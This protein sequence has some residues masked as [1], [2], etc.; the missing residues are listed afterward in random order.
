MGDL[1]KFNLTD[2]IIKYRTYTYFE[3]GT[4]I[5]DTLVQAT[6]YPFDK[7][8]TVDIDDEILGRAKSRIGN[9]DKIVYINAKSTDALEK[10][11]PLIPKDEAV[12]WFLD[13]HF[14]G[15][16]YGKIS[17]QDSLRQYMWDAFPLE[18][19][20]NI[21]K[22]LRDTSKDVF[23]IDDFVL[24]EEGDYDTIKEGVIWKFGYLQDELGLKTNSD[25]LYSAFNDTHNF[26]KS[27]GQ[28]GHLTI[29]PK[30]IQ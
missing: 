11:V 9:E 19:E 20:I 13:A 16:D 24:Y 6:S 3:T 23:I 27:L 7:F 22:S 25:F 28:Q 17:Y 15:A 4:G 30:E 29:T 5:G 26:S 10:Y 1:S 2:Y 14:P 21:I 8:Y 12:M 18:G